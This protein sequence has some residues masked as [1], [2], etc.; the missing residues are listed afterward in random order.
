MNLVPLISGL[1]PESD[2]DEVRSALFASPFYGSLRPHLS[3]ELKRR[4]EGENWTIRIGE[5]FP[6]GPILH[7]IGR[8]EREWRLV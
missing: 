6:L 7:E 1:S 3:S 4:I 8:I 5:N 2:Q